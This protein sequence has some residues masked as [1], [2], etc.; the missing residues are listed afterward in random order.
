MV[1]YTINTAN[2]NENKLVRS[3]KKGQ[4]EAY[5]VLVREYQT[6][7]FSII[8]GITLDREESLDIL[9]EVF[10]K[11]YNNIHSFE[12]RSSLYTWLRRIT[13]NECLNWRRRWKRRFKWKHQS[14]EEGDRGDSIELGTEKY[15]PET[16][17]LQ[18]E[19][20]KILNHELHS[21]PEDARTAFILKELEGL[22]YDEIARLL[23][24]KKGTVSS[25]IFYARRR[26]KKSLAALPEKE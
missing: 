12:E 25:R 7:L 9:Q 6:K 22:S 11:V 20:E 21:L 1:S 17:Y 4:D 10:L 5:R 16:I 14:L 2:W 24:I 15:G 19:L 3:L 13:V 8:Y 23:K 18:K 26:L